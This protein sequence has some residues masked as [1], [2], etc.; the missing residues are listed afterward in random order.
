MLVAQTAPNW[1]EQFPQSSPAPRVYQSMAYDS[2]HGQTV[3]FGG[4]DFTGATTYTDT[5]VWD[6]SNWTQ[7]FP[8]NSPPA[9]S[10][11]AMVYDS[12]HGQAVMFSLNDTWLWDGTSW[13]PVPPIG[14]SGRY[15]HAMAYDSAHSQVVLF[16]GADANFTSV[17]TLLGDTWVWDGQAW[18]QKF[19]QNSPPA[20]YQHAMAYD[21][22]HGEVVLFGGLYGNLLND[23]LSDTWLWDGN[24]WTQQSPQTSPPAL[25]GHAMVYDSNQ[26]QVVLYGGLGQGNPNETWL[27]DGS[28]WTA[29]PPE[30]NPP[31]GRSAQTMAY[32][33]AHDQVVMFGGYGMGSLAVLGDIWTYGVGAAQVAG[34]SIGSVLS[35]SDYGYGRNAN[36]APGSWIEIYGYNL[37]SDTRS[38]TGA[39]FNG[40]TAP[41]LLDKVSVMIAGQAAFIDYISPNQVNALLPSNIATGELQLT[42]TNGGLTGAPVDVTINAMLPGLLAPLDFLIGHNQ[43]VVAQLLDGTFV[44]PTGTIAGITSRPAKP[45]ESIVIYGIGFGA[46]TANIP[47]GQIAS[48]QTQLVLPFQISFGQ[49]PAQVLYSGLAPSLVGVYQFN[50]VVPAVPDSDLVPLTFSLGGVAGSQTLFTAVHQ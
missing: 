20:R 41:T 44:L 16:G 45:G 10:A 25:S 31:S 2:A 11:H 19:P 17:P 46:V 34:P 35:A 32:D 50:V 12:A 36:A 48:G 43:Y 21:S 33:S 6:G 18:T 49:A 29:A 26:A 28:N 37:A 13:T 14:P 1:T 42:I 3:M 47:A 39:D 15:G 38:W 4:Q 30:G 22:A 9:Q 27:W 5:W 7:K 23:S 40:N 8:Q 24:N